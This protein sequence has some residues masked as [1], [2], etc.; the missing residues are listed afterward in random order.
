[1][2]LIYVKSF[3]FGGNVVGESILGYSDLFEINQ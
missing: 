2:Y 1:M 3:P